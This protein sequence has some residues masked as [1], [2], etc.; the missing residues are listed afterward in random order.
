MPRTKKPRGVKYSKSRAFTRNTEIPILQP[1]FLEQTYNSNPTEFNLQQSDYDDVNDD[2]IDESIPV[3]SDDS[4]YREKQTRLNK[5]WQS[6]HVQLK[7]ALIEL[8]SQCNVEENIC[9]YGKCYNNELF[10]I[11]TVD[12]IYF[13]HEIKKQFNLCNCEQSN[14][15]VALTHRGLFSASPI[16][17]LIAFEIKLLEFAEKL[18][19]LAQISYESFCIALRHIHDN[20]LSSHKNIYKPFMSTFRQYILVK[21]EKIKFLTEQVVK[22]PEVFCPACPLKNSCNSGSLNRLTV[23]FDG[24][25]QL[26]RL[27]IGGNDNTE[28]D[29]YS[30]YFMDDKFFDFEKLYLQYL[31]KESSEENDPCMKAFKAA[32]KKNSKIL[33]NALDISG[34]VGTTCKHGIP[35]KFLNIKTGERCDHVLL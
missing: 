20:K 8:E 7:D 14:L 10:K 13:E 17:P 35:M 2:F 18:L 22:K 12:C 26:R 4:I 21:K 15:A 19:L 33:S 9:L 23:C 3:D 25:F 34:V 27:K 30:K 6:I 32:N 31:Q 24:C 11:I 16:N 5:S 29:Y 1:I 28:E